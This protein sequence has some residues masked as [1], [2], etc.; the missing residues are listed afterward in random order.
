MDKIFS[1]IETINRTLGQAAAW[2]ALVM[3]LAQ[4]F[5][6]VARYIFS[7]GIISVQEAAIY[8]H[9][10]IFL[11]GSAL[12]LQANEHV[13]VDIFYG[14]M[15]PGLRRWVDLIALLLFV[16]PVAVTIFWVS[17]PYVLRAW[18]TLEGSRQAG[19]IPAIF[20]LKTAILVFAVSVGLQ[21]I[22]TA[23]RLL[24]RQAVP[25]WTSDPADGA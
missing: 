24:R 9:A 11:A 20:L 10:L 16:V 3:L 14:K 18:S 7:Y 6:V 12:V 1:A 23:L 4:A 8:G 19:G 15:S 21:A 17:L 13:R 22:A 5:S 25:G 2:C